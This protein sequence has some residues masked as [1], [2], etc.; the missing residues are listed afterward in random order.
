[1]GQHQ[2][3]NNWIQSNFYSTTNI[4]PFNPIISLSTQSFSIKP[5]TNYPIP[6]L[7][8]QSFQKI[9][10]NIS[11]N[12]PQTWRWKIQRRKKGLSSKISKQLESIHKVQLIQKCTHISKLYGFTANPDNSTSNN[13]TNAIN[14]LSIH[15]STS[16]QNIMNNTKH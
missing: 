10:P 12:K 15:T 14:T 4:L 7:Q 1:M 11:I 9:Q 6:S 16:T 5:P 3:Q 8:P 13:F 2:N